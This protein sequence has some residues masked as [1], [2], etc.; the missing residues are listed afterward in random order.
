MNVLVFKLLI[1]ILL[2]MMKMIVDT[3]VEI[4]HTIFLP[5]LFLFALFSFFNNEAVLSIVRCSFYSRA[6]Y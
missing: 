5:I 4:K 3:I 6:T 2:M 1:S